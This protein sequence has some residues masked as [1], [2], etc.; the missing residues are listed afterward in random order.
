MQTHILSLAGILLAAI[1]LTS[2]CEPPAAAKTDGGLSEMVTQ[3]G[4]IHTTIKD[5]L[6]AGDDAGNE[7]AHVALHEV[8]PVLQK[9]IK[10]GTETGLA[11]AERD[12]VHAAAEVMAEIY[13]KIDHAQHTGGEIDYAEHATPLNEALITLKSFCK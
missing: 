6:E 9:L 4:T 13:G 11:A 12:K 10:S 5:G 8:F 2:G 3:L 7:S 1:V